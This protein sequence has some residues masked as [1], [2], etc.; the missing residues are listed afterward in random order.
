MVITIN[1]DGYHAK[2]RTK[3]KKVLISSGNVEKGNEALALKR[4]MTNV[5]LI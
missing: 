5:I 1:N 4:K 3:Q 2:A